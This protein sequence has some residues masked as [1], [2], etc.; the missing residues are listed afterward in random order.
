MSG[1]I[2]VHIHRLREPSA[3]CGWISTTATHC[4][5]EVLRTHKR[6]VSVD[7]LAMASFDLVDATARRVDSGGRC[8]LTMISYAQSAVVPSGRDW[9]S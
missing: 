9:L 8:G 4:C 7:P 5:Y 2:V 1:W 3:L 6:S